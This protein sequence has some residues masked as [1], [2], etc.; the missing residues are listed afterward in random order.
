MMIFC[1]DRP[2]GPGLSQDGSLDLMYL[3]CVPV[4][5]CTTIKN[6]LELALQLPVRA[7]ET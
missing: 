2:E 5:M 1:G 3:S 4:C 7:V 6:K